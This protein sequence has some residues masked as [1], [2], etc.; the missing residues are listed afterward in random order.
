MK[1]KNF[2]EQRL[3]NI[4]E[5]LNNYEEFMGEPELATDLSHLKFQLVQRLSDLHSIL[6]L[7][8]EENHFLSVFDLDLSNQ[9]GRGDSFL[10]KMSKEVLEKSN[11]LKFK[12]L[13]NAKTASM[14]ARP[15]KFLK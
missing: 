13:L 8:D 14:F 9:L 1:A 4:E 3:N 11:F 5:N 10:L 2:L 12:E 7:L 15:L 6:N